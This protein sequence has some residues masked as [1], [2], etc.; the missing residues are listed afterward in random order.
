MSDAV[1]GDVLPKENDN[2]QVEEL[3][4]ETLLR[5][6]QQTRKQ[7]ADAIAGRGMPEDKDDRMVL[8]QVLRDMDTTTIQRLRHD[9]DKKALEND[10]QVQNII[11]EMA[12]IN[13]RGLR[14]KEPV[15]VPDPEVPVAD[16]P[17]KKFTEEEKRIGVSKET[18]KDFLERMD[19]QQKPDGE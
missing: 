12:R 6:T 19:N 14:S 5:Y 11:A 9:V 16:L 7:L 1:E 10:Q 15:D 4:N 13:P 8:L 3:D 2:A 18:S 17:E